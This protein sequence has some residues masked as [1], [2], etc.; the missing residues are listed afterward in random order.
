MGIDVALTRWVNDIAQS[1][2]WTNAVSVFLAADLIAV[3]ALAVV[4]ALVRLPRG[5][6]DRT[7]FE[8]VVVV[9]VAYALSQAIGIIAFRERPFA[10]GFTTALI[11]KSP[12]E[13]SFPSDHA[14]LA[15][16]L[17]APLLGALRRNGERGVLLAVALMVA[18]GRVL[19]GV[20]Y[21]SDVLAGFLLAA[22]TTWA[23]HRSGI[24]GRFGVPVRQQ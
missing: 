18:F 1:G 6:R 10:V 15:A 19:V 12:L 16:A 24:A 7:A 20:H 14:V 5:I 9:C 2:P 8:V 22:I 23:V 4:V 17:V 11:E 13:K 3:L 21:V